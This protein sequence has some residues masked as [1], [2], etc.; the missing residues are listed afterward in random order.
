LKVLTDLANL[1]RLQ[2]S[3]KSSMVSSAGA[4]PGADAPRRP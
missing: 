2:S 3:D 4:G 1:L